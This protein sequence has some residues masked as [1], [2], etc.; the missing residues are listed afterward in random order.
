[1]EVAVLKTSPKWVE[2]VV[3]VCPFVLTQKD[4]SRRT[5]TGSHTYRL[6]AMLGTDGYSVDHFFGGCAIAWIEEMGYC[7]DRNGGDVS[8]ITTH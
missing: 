5:G 7:F 6:M 8:I 1:M 3:F 2:E 4:Q